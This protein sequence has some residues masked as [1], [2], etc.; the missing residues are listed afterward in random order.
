MNGLEGFR[1]QLNVIDEEWVRLLGER[2]QICRDV[3]HYKREH[4]IP[5]M[6]SARVEAVKERCASL[7]V[8][9]N[10]D[11]DFVRNL[12]AMIIRETCRIENEI[13]DPA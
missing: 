12:Y 13:I 5:M 3:A 2:I 10:I 6:Q 4:G 11:P 7:A 1:A 8:N 9:H